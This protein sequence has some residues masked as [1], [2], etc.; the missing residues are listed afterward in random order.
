M[1]FAYPLICGGLVALAVCGYCRIGRKGRSLLGVM[2]LVALGCALSVWD[3][4]SPWTR[5]QESAYGTAVFSE[6]I[7]RDASVFW[8]DSEASPRAAWL[9]LRRASYYSPQQLSGQMFNR[10]TALLG[11]ELNVQVEPVTL[12]AEICEVMVNVQVDA[13]PCQ[14]SKQGLEHMCTRH[15]DLLPPDYF[16][17]PFDQETHVRSSWQVRHPRTG[18]VIA[19]EYLYKCSDWVKP[20]DGKT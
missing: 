13:E 11:R 8:F 17:L 14:I 7:P 15:G 12:Q 9:V 19:T 6:D 16:V 1:I 10:R 18:R 3:S 5:I 2:S 20:E 4:R